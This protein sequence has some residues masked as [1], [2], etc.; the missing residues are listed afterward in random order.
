MT[1]GREKTQVQGRLGPNLVTIARLRQEFADDFKLINL[2]RTLQKVRREAAERLE[3]TRRR[4]VK[5]L[6]ELGLRE[7]KLGPILSSTSRL[8][9]G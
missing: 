7:Q 6:E 8:P 2:S 3:T 5:L 4:K 1:E 9:L